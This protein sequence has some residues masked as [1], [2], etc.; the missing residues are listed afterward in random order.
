MNLLIKNTKLN[1]EQNNIREKRQRANKNTKA[2]RWQEVSKS[3]GLRFEKE[4]K[5]SFLSR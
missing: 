4:P 1:K 2:I 5:Q 3:R